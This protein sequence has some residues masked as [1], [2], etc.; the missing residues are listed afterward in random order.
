MHDHVTR[1]LCLGLLCVAATVCTGK[2]V[3]TFTGFADTAGNNNDWRDYKF[4]ANPDNCKEICR[5]EPW[6]TAAEFNFYSRSC[7]LFKGDTPLSHKKDS[8]FMKKRCTEVT[9]TSPPVEPTKQPPESK[10]QVSTSTETITRAQRASKIFTAEKVRPSKRKKKG[11]KPVS[12]MVKML[13]RQ[14]VED[15]ITPTVEFTTTA[16]PYTT[17]ISTLSITKKLQVSTTSKPIHVKRPRKRIFV[18]K[19]RRRQHSRKTKKKPKKIRRIIKSRKPTQPPKTVVKKTSAPR[20]IVSYATRKSPLLSKLTQTRKAVN[21]APTTAVPFLD[22]NIEDSSKEIRIKPENG[23]ERKQQSTYRMP[24][25]RVRS[26]VSVNPIARDANRVDASR[27]HTGMTSA[28][29]GCFYRCTPAWYTRYGQFVPF[30]RRTYF[31]PL[32]RIRIPVRL[33]IPAFHQKPHAQP[34]QMT[35]QNP[36]Q[37]A[38]KN[39]RQIPCKNSTKH[40][41]QISVTN[42]VRNPGHKPVQNHGYK[43]VQNHGYKPVQNPVQNHG[44]KPVQNPVQNRGYKPVRNPVQNP[45]HKPV[46]NHGY[47]PVQNH[48]YKPVQNHGYKP[49]QN[50]GYNP[51]RNHGYN[52]VHYPVQQYWRQQIAHVNFNPWYPPRH[53]AVAYYTPQRNPWANNFQKAQLVP[54]KTHHVAV[55]PGGLYQP[56]PTRRRVYKQPYT[57]KPKPTATHTP[58]PPKQDAKTTAEAKTT[59]K[60][61]PRPKQVKRYQKSHVLRVQEK[62]KRLDTSTPQNDQQGQLKPHYNTYTLRLRLQSPI[63]GHKRCYL[64]QQLPSAPKIL[65]VSFKVD[66]SFNAKSLP[67]TY[68]RRICAFIQPGQRYPEF[69]LP[70]P[71]V[72]FTG[73]S[74]IR[75]PDEVKKIYAATAPKAEYDLKSIKL[76]TSQYQYIAV[77]NSPPIF[78]QLKVPMDINSAVV[79][80]DMT[81]MGFLYHFTVRL[82]MTLRSRNIMVEDYLPRDLTSLKVHPQPFVRRGRL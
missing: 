38:N 32:Y 53:S 47:K 4:M 71:L 78:R 63:S 33:R 37:D 21:I 76:K 12:L 16:A 35:D 23:T 61:P 7:Y 57:Y 52:P 29:R 17:P 11:S 25:I 77:Y 56:V 24:V 50:H 80:F 40:Q 48:G 54:K 8:V 36:L 42:P 75:N 82:P 81:R 67:V 2:Q 15:R 69:R 45:S 27:Q 1:N 59:P 10:T 41:V 43:P 28:R 72:I 26:K 79:S 65:V 5:S 14:S 31:Q 68:P 6:C 22:L 20:L 62:Q 44:Y 55:I 66:G 64:R 58:I 19:S 46:Q 49:V 70:S 18:R 73:T 3:C 9:T 74:F 34:P 30:T 51:V 39:Q 13:Y 60:P